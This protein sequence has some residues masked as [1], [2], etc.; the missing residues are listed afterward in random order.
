MPPRHYAVQYATDLNDIEEYLKKNIKTGDL[1]ITLGAGNI[2]TVGE[3]LAA[4]LK[5]GKC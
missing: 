3:H 1:V 4:D 5:R 2:Y